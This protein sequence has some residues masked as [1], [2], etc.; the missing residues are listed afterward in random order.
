MS[1]VGP[2]GVSGPIIP[3][4][5]TPSE[6]PNVTQGP[7]EI[8]V[9][10][11]FSAGPGQSGT[12]GGH[13]GLPSGGAPSSFT[14]LPPPAAAPPADSQVGPH[15][16]LLGSDGIS[17]GASVEVSPVIPA[18]Q[19][20]A[21]NMTYAAD[22]VFIAET[23]NL[24]LVNDMPVHIDA[25]GS[26]AMNVTVG[27]DGFSFPVLALDGSGENFL[28]ASIDVSSDLGAD[29]LFYDDGPIVP[30][31][32]ATDYADGYIADGGPAVEAAASAVAYFLL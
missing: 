30:A 11:T 13:G 18:S 22:G 23:T 21:G 3:V 20:A 1:G 6:G 12:I 16:Q 28:D 10:P 17:S 5:P 4:A 24:G 31:H 26:M 14:P 19:T 29:Q 2:T 25:H 27:V 32:A 8:D 15:S 7:P 9:S